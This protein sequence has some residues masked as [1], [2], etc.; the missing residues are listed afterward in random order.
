MFI[1]LS[2]ISFT[3]EDKLGRRI[4]SFTALATEVEPLSKES[5]L[6][7][8]GDL[9]PKTNYIIGKFL[10]YLPQL[11]KVDGSTYNNLIYDENGNLYARSAD[12]SPDSSSGSVIRNAEVL[13]GSSNA[14]VDAM[15]ND[16]NY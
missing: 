1:R 9:E 7:Y 5:Y 3:P 11:V 13:L 10:H 14:A 8:F 12:I 4:W 16:T 6:K 15:L 2:N